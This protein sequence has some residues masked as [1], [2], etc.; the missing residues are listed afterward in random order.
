MESALPT[1]PSREILGM[2]V[3]ATSYDDAIL[4]IS[5]WAKRGESRYVCIGAVNNVMSAY[6]DPAYMRQ[7]NGADLTTS[8]GMPLVWGLRRLGV[9]SA[10]RVYGPELT[11]RLCAAAAE[12]GIPI[13]F[14]GGHE[15]VLE[16]MVAILRDR[17]PALDVAYAFSPPFRPLD[18]TEQ[19]SIVDEIAA[20]G[21]R[22]L[23]VGLG[24]PKQER[25][26]AEH[27]ERVPAVMVGVGAAFDFIAGR[28]RQAPTWMQRAGL[29]WLFRLLVEPRRLWRR[30]L[31]QNPRFI[32]LFGRQLLLAALRRRT[33]TPIPNGASQ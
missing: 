5:T 28:T 8:D 2:R 9:P 11:P 23:F 10:T 21:A 32:V 20:S 6:D 29:E 26:M 17:H 12:L 27:R 3:D 33:S 1:L 13:G 18:E 24:A 22:I 25:W 30:Y 19:A 31:L 14:Y 15:E 7:M 4:R 16:E